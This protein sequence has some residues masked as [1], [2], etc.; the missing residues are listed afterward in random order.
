MDILSVLSRLLRL[1]I[2]ITYLMRVR[3]LL[4]GNQG[5]DRYTSKILCIHW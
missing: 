4:I 2:L 1:H 3:C 5:D